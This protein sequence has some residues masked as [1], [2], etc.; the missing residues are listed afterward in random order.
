MADVAVADLST[1]SGY[2][3]LKAKI[4]GDSQWR[5]LFATVRCGRGHKLLMNDAGVFVS[6]AEVDLIK[7][8]GCYHTR[9]GPIEVVH[10]GIG[11]FHNSVG[12]I[13]KRDSCGAAH[14]GC[15]GVR[16]STREWLALRLVVTM[17]CLRRKR[18]LH[19]IFA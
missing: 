16:T 19:A 1:L 3:E 8:Y 18:C 2:E 6:R 13:P 9:I 7:G 17:K 10:A 14:P 5:K 15:A 11:T 4:E 12:I